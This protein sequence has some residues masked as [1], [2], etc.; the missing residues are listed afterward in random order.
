LPPMIAFAVATLVP[1]RQLW[2]T[3]VA[4]VAA[5]WTGQI[6]RAVLH[7]QGWVETIWKAV[8]V[9]ALIAAAVTAGW[10]V[11]SRRE[12][13]LERARRAATEEQLRMARDL[14]DGVGHGLA[15]IAMQAGVGLHVLERDPAGARQALEA[16]REAS[17]D[18]LDALRSELQLLTGEDATAE[19]RPRPGLADLPQLVGRVRAG[20][21]QVDLVVDGPEPPGEI[22]HAAY[23]IVQEALTNVLRHADASEVTVRIHGG[24]GRTQVRVADNGSGGPAPDSSGGLGIAGMRDR[25]VALGGEL[26][27]GPLPQ[28]G[29][30]VTAVLPWCAR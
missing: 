20:G 10:W 5:L 30:E 16:I 14:H 1:A 25:A 24:A 22:D 26:H 12:A 18:A 9:S 3:L 4:S 15:V 8:A 29:F 21:P 17:K 19:L 2:P 28:R 13:G 23:A 11:S 7:E 27:A 6:L